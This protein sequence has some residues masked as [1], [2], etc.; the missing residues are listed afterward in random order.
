MSVTRQ[1]AQRRQRQKPTAPADMAERSNA[2]NRLVATA[3]LQPD[4]RL[5]APWSGATTTLLD[6]TVSQPAQH[7]CL[8]VPN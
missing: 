3:R 1:R 6:G 5:L 7:G 4:P 2:I 8:S